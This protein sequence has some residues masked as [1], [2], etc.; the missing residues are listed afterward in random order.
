[1][2]PWAVRRLPRLPVGLLLRLRHPVHRE[3]RRLPELPAAPRLRLPL[4]LVLPLELPLRELRVRRGPRVHPLLRLPGGRPRPVLLRPGR[5]GP[6]RR[7]GHRHRQ[8]HVVAA[9][10]E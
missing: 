8:N 7:P 9:E 4:E 2:L 5:L 10:E 6:A 3:L 1:M